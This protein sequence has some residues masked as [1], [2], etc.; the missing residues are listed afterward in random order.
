MSTAAYAISRHHQRRTSSLTRT[1]LFHL[2]I[3]PPCYNNP[4]APSRA[5]RSTS[6]RLVSYTTRLLNHHTSLRSLFLFLLPFLPRSSS[7]RDG[8]THGALLSEDSHQLTLYSTYPTPRA[9]AESFAITP[10]YQCLLYRPQQ[11]RF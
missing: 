4:H 11:R 5:A 8:N 10:F 7:W 9:A 2:S 3:N 6:I 1:S